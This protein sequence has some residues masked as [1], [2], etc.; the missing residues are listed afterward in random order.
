MSS[1]ES[2]KKTQ[3]Q[4]RFCEFC[5][6]N[7]KARTTLYK[8]MLKQHPEEW[9]LKQIKKRMER[10]FQCKFCHCKFRYKNN[11]TT[12]IKKV[13]KTADIVLNSIS[14]GSSKRKSHLNFCKEENCSESFSTIEQLKHHLTK[15]HFI[16]METTYMTFMSY[17]EFEDWRK[18]LERN[19]TRFMPRMKWPRA[20]GGFSRLYK[21]MRS[22]VYYPTVTEENRKR[23]LKL[24]GSYKIGQHC[25]AQLTVILYPSGLTK[26]KACLTHYGH[27]FNGKYTYGYNK[28]K[29]K[30][31]KD[32][33][34]HE[35]ADLYSD[36]TPPETEND[37][38]V[39]TS[40]LATRETLRD[41][42][43]DLCGFLQGLLTTS[44]VG[45]DNLAQIVMNLNS[46]ISLAG[47]KPTQE[48]QFV[49]VDVVHNVREIEAQ[50]QTPVH[51]I[52]TSAAKD[53]S[54]DLKCDDQ[55]LKPK[56][57]QQEVVQEYLITESPC[58]QYILWA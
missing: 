55:E 13:H 22:G 28:N 39:L 7:F 16:Q 9:S 42:A 41:Q 19:T 33:V 27:E 12:H 37:H 56:L 4:N 34:K 14:D 38:E 21:C 49:P 50:E 47:W 8:H 43:K 1:P 24:E 20:D 35:Y 52:V 15:D 6:T 44:E 54:R 57:E 11:L 36:Q 5:G 26:V 51:R 53:N 3:Q 45:E 17:H 23:R 18:G 30:K 10:Q 48:S 46:S 29:I 2:S 40:S 32:Q 31:R 58:E 25:P